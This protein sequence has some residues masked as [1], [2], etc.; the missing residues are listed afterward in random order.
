[1]SNIVLGLPKMLAPKPDAIVS[2]GCFTQLTRIQPNNVSVIQSPITTLTATPGTAG[3]RCDMPF[4]PSEVRFSVPT[5][6]G[7]NVYLDCQRSRLNMRL[8]VAVTTASVGAA[9]IS[10]FLQSGAASWFDRMDTLNQNG[11]AIDS[12]NMMAII[13]AHK[14]AFQYDSAERDSV[15]QYGFASEDDLNNS[16]N[17]IQGHVISNMTVTGGVLPIS[18]TYYDYSIPLPN[19]LIGA[20]ARNFCPVGAL[21]KLDISLW[22]NAIA[23]IVIQ[24]AAHT[25]SPAFQ[26]T[27]DNMSLDLQ[28]IYLDQKSAALLGSPRETYVHG[29]TN[30]CATAP[31]TASAGQQSLLIGLRGRSIR[32]IATKF[33]ESNLTTAGSCNGVFDSKAPLATALSLF[34]AGKSRFPNVPHNVVQAPTTVFDHALQA[35]DGFVPDKMKYG[36]SWAAVTTYLATGATVT[37]ANGYSNWFALAGSNTDPSSLSTFT[38]GENL[39]IASTSALNGFDAS[40]SASHFLEMNLLAQPTYAGQAYFI[41]AQDII[42]VIDLESGAIESRV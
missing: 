12:V 29:I 28:Y 42:Y 1:M 23:P 35:A 30:R 10:S 22:T 20:G 27:I 8:K 9:N 6:M 21:A 24:W 5:G 36:G 40:T 19:S 7:K 31:Y 11:V 3:V 18:Y 25:T 38:F 16:R 13:E 4:S 41:S 32:S 39:Q 2:E 15:W 14:N 37:S 26:F 34:L 17:Y 33:V